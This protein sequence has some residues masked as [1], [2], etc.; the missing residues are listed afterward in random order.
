[1][2]DI[3][4]NGTANVPGQPLSRALRALVV[5]SITE[6][7]LRNSTL[8]EAEHV[9]L[10]LSREGSAPIRS[11]L[12]GAGLD[13]DGLGAALDGERAAS[14]RV[15]GV[16]PA[17]AERLTAATRVARP[18]WGASFKEALTR[19]HRVGTANHRQRTT[20]LDLLT[21]LMGLELGTLPRAL[22][23]AGVDRPAVL[24]SARHAA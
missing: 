11:A 7:Q 1:M 16:T 24:A 13:P 18:R 4:H 15:A 22:T 3:H 17:P 5:R 14:L 10:A 19:A 2:S 20:E 8:V 12:A 23:I 9:L 21:A 6:A